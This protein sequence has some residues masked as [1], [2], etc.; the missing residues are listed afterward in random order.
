MHTFAHDQ[1]SD[2]FLRLF[3]AALSSSALATF[4]CSDFSTSSSASESS[5]ACNKRS[6][7]CAC[8]CEWFGA[9]S[10]PC[11]FYASPLKP[12]WIQ[13][14][15][16]TRQK[17]INRNKSPHDTNNYVKSQL[18]KI[19]TFSPSSHHPSFTPLGRAWARR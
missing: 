16:I 3:K 5:S 14:G 1:Q 18:C 10:L 8:V 15:R 12:R 17:A 4:C 6:L 7:E 2:A 9:S 11:V 13:V 19:A